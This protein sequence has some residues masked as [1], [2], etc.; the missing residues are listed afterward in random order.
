M[1]A[2]P[3]KYIK[4]EF[5]C[6]N[7]KL[8]LQS[9]KTSHTRTLYVGKCN[10]ILVGVSVEQQISNFLRGKSFVC[11]NFLSIMCVCVCAVFFFFF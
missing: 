4:W 8:K 2:K 7:P 9:K 6:E 10:I 5:F 3:L 11:R 1:V